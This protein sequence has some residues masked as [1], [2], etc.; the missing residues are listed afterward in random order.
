MQVLHFHNNDG[1]LFV[2]LRKSWMEPHCTVCGV[3]NKQKFANWHVTSG[4]CMLFCTDQFDGK[5]VGAERAWNE[6]HG[7]FIK[8]LCMPLKLP[9]QA[10]CRGNVLGSGCVAFW[11]IIH[12]TVN[13]WYNDLPLAIKEGRY[14]WSV[15]IIWCTHIICQYVSRKVLGNNV[16]SLCA[17]CRYVQSLL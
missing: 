2:L 9:L 13:F 4:L 16:T 5:S 10:S 7:M 3:E 6:L 17:I 11:Y 14:K 8:L 15:T 12:V 1:I